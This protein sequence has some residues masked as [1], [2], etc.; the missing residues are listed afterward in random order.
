MTLLHLY[1]SEW[2]FKKVLVL[3]DY[4]NRDRKTYYHRLQTGDTYQARQ[5]VDLT[6][7]LE[8]FVDG[9]WEE[10]LRVKEQILTLKTIGEQGITRQVLDGDEL[11]IIDFV[12]TVGRITSS[13][14]VDILHIPKR[15][16]QAKLKRLENIRAVEKQ[17]AGPATYYVI[18]KI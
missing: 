8:Y 11:K 10:A 14:V 17:G 4:Y 13:D 12:V 6:L 9:F 5:G 1:Q 16:A 18:P 7:W 15:T 3:E 2:G